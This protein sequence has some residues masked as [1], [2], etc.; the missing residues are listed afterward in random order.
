MSDLLPIHRDNAGIVE[1]VGSLN[2][3]NRLFSYDEAYL[4]SPKATPLSFSPPLISQE[5]SEESFRPYF[6]GIL[7][8]GEPRRTLAKELGVR[9][10]DYLEIL[11]QSGLDCV[12]DVIINLDAYQAQYG[13]IP[14]D[15]QSM[16][17][18]FS[19][20]STMTLSNAISRLSLAGTQGKVGL[21]H[22]PSFPLSQGWERPLGGAASTHVL[23]TESLP[24]LNVIEYLCM[25]CAERCGIPTAKT[26]LLSFATPI[27]CSERFDRHLVK[28]DEKVRVVR[29]HQED[30]TQ[31]LGLLPGSKYAELQPSTATNVSRFIAEHSA[32]P[33]AD[34]TFFASL[35]CF[36]YLVGN[37]DNHLKNL[38]LL[39]NPHASF[40]TLAP[41]YDIVSTTFFSHFDR[42]MA[43]CIGDTNC[44]DEITP[45]SFH[46]F[47]KELKIT[48]KALQF[49]CASL[50]ANAVS[51]LKEAATEISIDFPIAPYIADDLEE[52]MYIRLTVL[53]D[54][55]SQ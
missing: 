11:A 1:R 12:G 22:D 5:Y 35:S 13:Y 53:K 47:A 31:A 19:H 55:S 15:K 23:K 25:K 4:N 48:S 18:L 3:K 50:S 21:F 6:E 54:F 30:F 33:L 43:M 8:E 27:L 24:N 37:C 40:T 7:P 10:E 52:D 42:S 29:L 45:N 28:T 2:R 39:N 32:K 41:A 46:L 16:N 36:N 26:N 44:I 14:L 49:M 9:E 20:H 38:S 34:L 17:D 51:A